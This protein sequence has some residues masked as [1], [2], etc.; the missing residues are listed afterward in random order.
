MYGTGSACIPVVLFGPV[1]NAI[2]QEQNLTNNEI[3]GSKGRI[4]QRTARPGVRGCADGL[5]R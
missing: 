5:D 1:G 3:G 2:I 4:V